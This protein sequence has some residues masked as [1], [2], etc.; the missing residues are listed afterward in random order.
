M[1]LSHADS[2]WDLDYEQ[3]LECQ[4]EGYVSKTFFSLTC[5]ILFSNFS[6]N[7]TH[8]TLGAAPCYNWQKEHVPTQAW[9]FYGDS[10]RLRNS[11]NC[12]PIEQSTSQSAAAHRPTSWAG[13][14][15]R[16]QLFRQAVIILFLFQS[17]PPI[18]VSCAMLARIG[19]FVDR[20]D[21][22]LIVSSLQYSRQWWGRMSRSIWQ[23]FGH[24]A[25][26][27]ATDFAVPARTIPCLYFVG[28][29]CGSKPLIMLV[30]IL[31][32]IQL[33]LAYFVQKSDEIHL[34]DFPFCFI[35]RLKVEFDIFE[36]RF[37]PRSLTFVAYL[38]SMV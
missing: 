36:Q 3:W 28:H 6:R 20:L 2:E 8:N 11:N 34:F 35:A 33:W 38:S 4:L 22:I 23:H 24:W 18:C 21:N 14:D 10:E 25:T 16:L 17:S 13:P 12:I 1:K 30:V 9:F 27:I 7:W 15:W 31:I 5:R 26:I 32:T 19:G 37:G 29:A